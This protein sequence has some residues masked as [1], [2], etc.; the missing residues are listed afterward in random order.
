ML[1]LTLE[2][3]LGVRLQLP[4]A[5]GISARA[6]MLDTPEAR[7]PTNFYLWEI[8]RS[9][10]NGDLRASRHARHTRGRS[11]SML[12]GDELPETALEKLFKYS[13]S[14]TIA[15]SLAS[16]EDAKNQDVGR[17]AVQENADQRL[18]AAESSWTPS[19]AE[20]LDTIPR[21][22]R[23]PVRYRYGARH[24]LMGFCTAVGE[25]EELADRCPTVEGHKVIYLDSP[26]SDSYGQEGTAYVSARA[27]TGRVWGKP[28]D[29][30][31]AYRW[32][33]ANSEEESTNVIAAYN[34]SM[35][36]W[37]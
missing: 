10:T 26:L 30:A 27:L 19:N 14:S 21:L 34:A 13:S 20:W 33:P 35:G 2:D 22:T 6:D 18:A 1:V 15:A 36:R 7:S 37:E 29:D 32:V 4:A 12:L 28:R 31:A 8:S 24:Q 9:P 17:T 25:H 11:R 23:D 5:T 16:M 3:R